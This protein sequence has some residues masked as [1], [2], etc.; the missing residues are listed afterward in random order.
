MRRQRL[1]V[2]GVILMGIGL[3]AC[4]GGPSA[5]PAAAHKST[6]TIA[7]P[8]PTTVTTTPPTTV[9]PTTTTQPPPPPTT[10]P[11]PSTPAGGVDASALDFIVGY[12]MAG[13]CTPNGAINGCEVAEDSNSS[14]AAPLAGGAYKS[15]GYVLCSAA[16]TNTQDYCSK[17][18]S[19][20]ILDAQAFS[21]PAA[22]HAYLVSQQGQNW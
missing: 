3:A 8:T 15:L 16:E 1:V 2:P 6:T 5:S 22:A 20:G 10:D 12:I 7:Q 17:N 4:G 9:A 18:D 19:E 11:P 21:S 14:V 13:Y